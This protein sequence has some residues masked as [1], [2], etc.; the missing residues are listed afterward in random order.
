MDEPHELLH[1]VA[2][3]VDD[4]TS[5]M[6]ELVNRQVVVETHL[7]TLMAASSAVPTTPPGGQRRQS[8]LPGEQRAEGELRRST[9]ESGWKAVRNR[10]MYMDTVPAY[11]GKA[12][13]W[14]AIPR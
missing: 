5:T 1:R 3:Q 12:S 4:L 13:D 10:K 8:D 7:G 9:A 6:A 11:S 2:R 14:G